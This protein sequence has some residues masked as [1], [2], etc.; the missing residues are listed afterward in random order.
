MRE[1]TVRLRFQKHCLGNVK[2]RVEIGGKKLSYFALPRGSGDQVMFLPTWWKSNMIMAADVLSRGQREAKEIR[3][4]PMVDGRPGAVPER[5][6]KRYWAPN[7][8]ARHEAF[9]PG[10]VIG[11]NCV[12]PD[13]LTLEDVWK[14]MAVAGRFGG[15]SPYR[16]KEF[17][18]F[19]VVSVQPRRLSPSAVESAETIEGG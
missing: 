15:I 4:D 3:F 11:V 9:W 7:R 2:S 17:G 14:L 6:F 1:L 13:R 10:A 8:F 5:L 16:P 18:F 12:V 19:D